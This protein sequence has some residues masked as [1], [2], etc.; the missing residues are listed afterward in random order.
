MQKAG[1]RKTD[2]GMLTRK[3]KT[4][5]ALLPQKSKKIKPEEITEKTNYY[6]QKRRKGLQKRAKQ[7]TRGARPKKEKKT[8]KNTQKRH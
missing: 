7:G 6:E 4:P 1:L 2:S 3:P 5:F 8:S